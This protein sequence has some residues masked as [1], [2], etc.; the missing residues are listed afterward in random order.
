MRLPSVPASPARAPRRT[1]ARALRLLVPALLL[2]ACNGG[3]GDGDA[4]TRE[5][6]IRAN[7]ELRKIPPMSAGSD[8]ARRVTLRKAGVT[9]EDLTRFVAVHGRRDARY[10]S[11][12]WHEIA[13]RLEADSTG[14][15]MRVSE[16]SRTLLIDSTGH[17]SFGM[18]DSA[19][20]RTP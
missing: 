17:S 19:V 18:P 1:A 2:A 5:Q 15:G 10:L 20:L 6:F 16:P 13:N 4:I 14:A 11:E 3:G 8:S 7:V 12:T 9:E